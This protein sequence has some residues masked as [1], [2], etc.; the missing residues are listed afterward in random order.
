MCIRDRVLPGM[1][2][3]MGKVGKKLKRKSL[4]ALSLIHIYM[5]DRDMSSFFYFFSDEPDWVRD[6]LIP[7]LDVYKR[8]D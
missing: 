6:E 2:W 3:L 5:Q 4:D 1:G 7:Q 8:Q